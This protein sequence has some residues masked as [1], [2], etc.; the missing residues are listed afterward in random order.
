[1]SVLFAS[2]FQVRIY[3]IEQHHAWQV[4]GYTPLSLG[5]ATKHGTRSEEFWVGVISAK[6]HKR[7]RRKRQSV[8]AN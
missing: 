8:T 2:P 1:M 6:N 5:F 3:I 7:Q 4:L